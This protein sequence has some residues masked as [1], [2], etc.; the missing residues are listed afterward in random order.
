MHIIV[1]S[2][3]NKVPLIK[4]VKA[5]AH[6]H[7]PTTR[8]YGADVNEKCIGQY[9]V[10]CFWQS[11][12]L[13][14]LHI[15]SF[16][17]YC[18]AHQITLVLPTRDGELLY[19][20]RHK[21]RL[22]EAGISI[23][24]SDEAIVQTC[25]DK[26]LFS[27]RLAELDYPVIPSYES[28]PPGMDAYVVKERYGSGS[29]AIGINLS[30]E[31]AAVHML[32]LEHP[33]IQPYI[34]GKEYSVDVYV[35]G[36]KAKGAIVRARE[37]VVHGESQITTTVRIPEVETM[38]M[39]IAEHFPFQGHIIFQVLLDGNQKIHIIECNCRV[40]G[41]STLSFAAGLQ[42]VYWFMQESI[43]TTDK[44]LVFERSKEEKRLIR[45]AEDMLI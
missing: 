27:K 11:P 29:K 38:M 34:Q 39:Q 40:G 25:L 14:Q 6:I 43:G 12:L 35:S 28:I 37:L 41:A 7:N 18:T 42:S 31:Q 17:D 30:E 3:A 1:M 9:F 23:M 19:F 22:L 36:R 20:A 24:I 10:D 13:E 4:A 8:V 21:I 32:T 2:I 15:D 26:F 16:I 45:H 33:L 44:E 5:A